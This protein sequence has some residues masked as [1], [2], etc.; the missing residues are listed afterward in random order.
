MSFFNALISSTHAC[1]TKLARLVVP[2]V[3][4]HLL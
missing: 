4:Q 1:R 3:Q 2:V